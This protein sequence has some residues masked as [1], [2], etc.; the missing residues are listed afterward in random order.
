MTEQLPKEKQK[1]IIDAARKLFAHYGFSK[2]TMEEI[3]ADIEMG[4]ASL[5]YYFP[6]KESLFYA[7]L[8]QE[9]NEFIKEMEE[10]LADKLSASEKL[11]EFVNKRLVYFQR[12]LNLGTLSFHTFM[13]TKSFYKKFFMDFEKKELGLIN[14]IISEGKTNGEFDKK[15]HRKTGTVLLHIL[16]GLRIRTLRIIKELKTSDETIHG[17]QSEMNIAIKIFIKGISK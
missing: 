12:F 1:T 11:I 14:R 8:T 16:H 5:Y 6:T 7:V 2:V 3:A 15:L 17:L 9:Q 4:K 13:D 10:I